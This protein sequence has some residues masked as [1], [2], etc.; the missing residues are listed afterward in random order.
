MLAYK[1][2]RVEHNKCFFTEAGQTIHPVI[3]SLRLDYFYGLKGLSS[4]IC[5]AESGIIR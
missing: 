2:F 4:E 5:L 3:V 1:G